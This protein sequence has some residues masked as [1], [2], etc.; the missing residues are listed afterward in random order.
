M[1]YN[2]RR[3]DE[4]GKETGHV[5]RSG[6]G[7]KDIGFSLA[8][9]GLYHYVEGEVIREGRHWDFCSWECMHLYSGAK[10]D[11]QRRDAGVGA[12]VA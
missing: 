9:E 12:G 5:D 7:G 4:C 8:Y 1:Q 6:V 11:A 3:C 10:A 2:V